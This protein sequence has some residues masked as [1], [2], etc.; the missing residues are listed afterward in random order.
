MSHSFLYSTN[1]T[2]ELTKHESAL[3]EAYGFLEA[4]DG[5]RIELAMK[6]MARAPLASKNGRQLDSRGRAWMRY[7]ALGL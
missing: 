2:R 7:P 3:E 1:M 4:T 5:F 6:L